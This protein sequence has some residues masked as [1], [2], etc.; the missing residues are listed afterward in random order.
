MGTDKPF[1][2]APPAHVPGA[3]RALVSHDVYEQDGKKYVRT[4]SHNPEYRIAKDRSVRHATAQFKGSKKDRKRF[5]AAVKQALANPV[6]EGFVELSP[7]TELQKEP[8]L[9]IV[10]DVASGQ[11]VTTPYYKCTLIQ[12]QAQTGTIVR[13]ARVKVDPPSTPTGS[14]SPTTAATSP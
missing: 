10:Y 3:D 1:I 6:P 5:K 8:T 14:S 12:L 4:K 7:D 13:S 9:D 11:W 2:G